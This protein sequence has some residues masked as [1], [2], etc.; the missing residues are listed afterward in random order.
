MSIVLAPGARFEGLLTFRGEA[1]VE[2]EL[3]GEV[4]AE[5]RLEVG[6]EARIEARVEVDELIVEGQIEG[7]VEARTRVRVAS[8]GR[9]EGRVKAPR[10]AVEDGGRIQARS[11]AAGSGEES[12]E[13]AAD[14]DEARAEAGRGGVDESAP[15]LLETTP[16]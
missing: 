12:S 4:V 14:G 10:L 3:R 1:R 13:P 5:G 2:G 15:P 9:I 7:D 6:P 11:L 8:S 16:E